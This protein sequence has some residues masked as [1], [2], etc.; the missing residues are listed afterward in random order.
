M[1]YEPNIQGANQFIM[2]AV[3]ILGKD[4]DL[5]TYLSDLIKN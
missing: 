1:N 4:N 5:I 3:K 2:S